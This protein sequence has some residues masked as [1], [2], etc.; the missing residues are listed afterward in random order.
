MLNKDTGFHRIDPDWTRGR[1]IA[2]AEAEAIQRRQNNM[3]RSVRVEIK[4][5][6][7]NDG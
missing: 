1:E 2:V 7:N 6:T 5:G 3:A 4:E